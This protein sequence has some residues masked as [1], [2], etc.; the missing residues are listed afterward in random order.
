MTTALLDDALFE[1]FSSSIGRVEESESLPPVCYTDESFYAFEKTA[2]FHK[3]WLCAGRASWLQKPGDYFT[4]SHANEPIIVALTKAGEIAAMSAVCQHRAM[5]VAEGHGNARAFVCPYH[6]W[7]Y[8]LD[9]RLVGAPA[10]E[11]SCGF[12]RPRGGAAAAGGRGLERVC[13]CQPGPAG[14]PPGAAPARG[15]RRARQP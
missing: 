10:M 8:G 11:R 14:G 2:I 1:S 6:H 5:L 3:E 7:T 9:G 12:D 4:L 15:H 13:L